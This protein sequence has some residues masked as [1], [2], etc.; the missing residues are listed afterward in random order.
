M[1][2]SL[3][4]VRIRILVFM[5]IMGPGLITAV[6]D[7]D[8]GGIATYSSVG[9]AYGYDMLW[10]LFL[11]TFSLGIIQEMCARM[12]AVTGKGLSDLIRENFGVRWTVIAMLVL[13]AANAA[14]TVAEFAG[15]AAGMELFGVNRY[16]SVPIAALAV[17]LLVV[18]G[19]YKVAEKV[20]LLFAVF[21]LAYVAAGIITPNQ[22]WGLALGS[23]LSVFSPVLRAVGWLG[24]EI[25]P[26]GV[27]QPLQS[28]PLP[29]FRF[30]S[31]FILLFIA[32]IGTTIAPWMQFY[33]QSSVRD[34]GITAE[35]YRY[36]RWDVLF[37][38][39]VTDFVSFFIIITTAA[40]LNREGILVNTAADAAIALQ[41]LAGVYST[42]LFALGLAGASM[43]AAS[44]LP[45]STAYA[46]CEALGWESGISKGWN[47]APA[48]FTLYTS[49]IVLGAGVVLLPDLD[50]IKIMLLSQDINGILLPVVLIFMLLLI[51][52]KR[53]MG[54]YVNGRVYNILAWTTTIA[55][56]MLTVLLL[57]TSIFPGLL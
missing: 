28:A 10:M 48:F 52:N 57:V 49:L 21:Q 43:L 51:N 12:G 53:L 54:R 1:P 45:L 17:W 31:Q 5:G 37:G 36:E 15:I 2:K 23:L 7:N 26:A 30:E 25:L 18:K 50:L 14:T 42:Q 46:V 16:I 38:A 27:S 39:F 4:S 8:A 3:R 33:I 22:D 29:V 20:F 35:E 41:P 13:L 11:I 34:K 24:Q 55:V 40:T 47:E 32:T 56:I 9:A 6:A 44:I 19:S